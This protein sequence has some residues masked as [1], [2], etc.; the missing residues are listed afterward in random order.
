MTDLD[1]D[2]IPKDFKAPCQLCGRMF[3]P[4]ELRMTAI[5]PMTLVRACEQCRLRRPHA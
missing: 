5:G 4:T 3:R 2:I 1:A